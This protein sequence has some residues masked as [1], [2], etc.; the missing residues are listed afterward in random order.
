MKIQPLE[1]IFMKRNIFQLLAFLM[2]VNPL[3]IT[4][5][6]Q[7]PGFIAKDKEDADPQNQPNEVAPECGIC[8][9]EAENPLPLGCSHV[10]CT[11]CLHQQLEMGLKNFANLQKNLKCPIAECPYIMRDADILLVAGGDDE[12]VHR[13]HSALT[14]LA[15]DKDKNIKY[16]PVQN[17]GAPI[18]LAR[19]D[20]QIIECS[21]CHNRYC[22]ECSFSHEM[23]SPCGR[24][25]ADSHNIRNRENE[26][27]FQQWARTHT[28]PCPG[29]RK[30]IEKNDGCNHMTCRRDAGGCG[31]EFCWVCLVPWRQANHG[32]FECNR[33]PELIDW[34][35]Q[36]QNNLPAANHNNNNN[37]EEERVH[38]AMLRLLAQGPYAQPAQ[39]PNWP[40]NFQD[41]M[42]VDVDDAMLAQMGILNEPVVQVMYNPQGWPN[43]SPN[44]TPFI[45]I[46][47]VIVVAAA[48]FGAYKL[49]TY[50]KNKKNGVEH[51][52][53]EVQEVPV[54]SS[55]NEREVQ[56][57]AK[58]A[59]QKPVKQVNRHAKLG[60]KQ[61]NKIA[62]I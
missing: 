34:N 19:P 62:R 29:C 20:K 25:E 24:S 21:V 49:Y 22:S 17:C 28:K 11:A 54:N 13:F 37:D 41:D 53:I 15:M 2:L 16:C 23:Q 57:A 45:I 40:Q 46:G 12:Y 9:M 38:R 59:I 31:H 39:Q 55:E 18:E 27:Q 8:I 32:Y 50:F 58:P 30:L 43:R 47:G 56:Q 7:S 60:R 42:V 5:M 3:M 51:E 52:V 14:K 6:E 10:F 33:G 26:E 1:V 4:A 61:K 35:N 36:P 44:F 48:S